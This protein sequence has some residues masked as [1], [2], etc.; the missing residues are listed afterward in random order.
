MSFDS[1]IPLLGKGYDSQE[2]LGSFRDM[3][4]TTVNARAANQ[5]MALEQAQEDRTL[6]DLARQQQ[7]AAGLSTL[8]QKG[9]TPEQLASGGYLPEAQQMAGVGQAVASTKKTQADAASV[10]QKAQ[11]EA[12]QR[13]ATLMHGADEKTW[14]AHRE[15]VA[16]D[17]ISSTGNTPEAL[18]FAKTMVDSIGPYNPQT[19]QAFK[20]LVVPPTEQ[21]KMAEARRASAIDRSFKST[22]AQKRDAAAKERA[23]IMASTKAETAA[24][25]GTTDLRKEITKDPSIAKFKRSAA[26]LESLK[27]LAKDKS[28]ASDLA[29]VFAFMKSLDPD[30][31]VREAEYDNAASTGIPSDRLK[32]EMGKYWDGTKLSAGQRSQFIK[33]AEAAQSGHKKAYEAAVKTYRYA[34]EKSGIDLKE[35]GL[36][37]AAN[38]EAAAAREWLKSPEAVDHPDAPGVRARLQQLEG[39]DIN[40]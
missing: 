33:A 11:Q 14:D 36:D 28:G 31:A 27:T 26:E 30:S 12:R 20:N 39:G 25:A 6:A 10:Q 5:R 13:V 4:T 18:Q 37:D 21:T 16:N 32:A 29:I 8:L 7:R 3:L 17:I 15:A 19:A 9:A 35:I 1:R 38:D 34:A 22:E 24:R 2:T 40:L 23:A